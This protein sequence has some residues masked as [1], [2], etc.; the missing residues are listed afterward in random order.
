MP[1]ISNQTVEGGALLWAARIPKFVT[2]YYG[3]IWKFFTVSEEISGR[4]MGVIVMI[5]ART[6][7]VLG[8]MNVT[9]TT[10]INAIA[11]KY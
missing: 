3:N 1:L 10:L 6:I 4:A 7:G 2:L 11:N 5:S 8:M 9:M